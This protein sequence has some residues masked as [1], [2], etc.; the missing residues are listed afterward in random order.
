VTWPPTDPG[1]VAD[2]TGAKLWDN[3]EGFGLRVAVSPDGPIVF[4]I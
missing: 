2:D 4:V 3:S 1:S